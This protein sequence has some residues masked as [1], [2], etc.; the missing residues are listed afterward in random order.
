MSNGDRILSVI[1]WSQIVKLRPNPLAATA[2]GP[3][4][5]VARSYR[6]G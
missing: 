5:H 4:R 6:K 1:T 3:P 2:I